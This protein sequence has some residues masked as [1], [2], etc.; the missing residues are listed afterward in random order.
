MIKKIKI[1][2]IK[3]SKGNIIKFFNFKLRLLN[4]YGEIY[5]SEV[6]K[7][8]FKGWKFHERKNQVMTIS[9]GIVEFSFKKKN[10][11]KIIK[12]KLSYPN[13]L[14]AIYIPK[15]TFYSFKCLSKQ[16]A[17]IVNLVDESF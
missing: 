14:Y 12:I 15:K 7:N 13:N 3:N 16:K 10:Q 8:K 5:F 17:I 9:S 6:K 11:G 4:K 1:K 2:K